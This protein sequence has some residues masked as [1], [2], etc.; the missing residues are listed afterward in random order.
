VASRFI[1]TISAEGRCAPDLSTPTGCGQ[2][3]LRYDPVSAPA[4]RLALAI[5]PDGECRVLGSDPRPTRCRDR[6]NRCHRFAD[7]RS[8]SNAARVQTAVPSPWNTRKVPFAGAARTESHSEPG[9]RFGHRVGRG[10][11]RMEA[12]YS[13]YRKGHVDGPPR[14]NGAWKWV[15]A[16]AARRPSLDRMCIRPS[17]HSTAV[18][19][20]KSHQ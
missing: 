16:A 18:P 3:V 8:A 11:L 4:A 10:R 6:S 5:R 14:C 7:S 9:T 15:P 13:G 17:A 12:A 1:D 2:G 19:N 20:Q